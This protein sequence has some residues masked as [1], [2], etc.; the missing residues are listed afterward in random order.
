MNYK[1]LISSFFGFL[2]AG[3]KHYSMLFLCVCLCIL[4]DCLTGII[5]SKVKHKK[6]TSTKMTIGFYKKFSFI[7]SVSF[8]IFL[9][10]FI[11]YFLK[12]ID[13]DIQFNSPFAYVISFYIMLTECISICENLIEINPNSVPQF[14]K[15]FLLKGIDEIDKK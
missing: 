12:Y 4:F 9:D 8:G 6:I 7:V 14:I 10:V 11:P 1:I 3:L 2:L 13:V 5:K 15:K